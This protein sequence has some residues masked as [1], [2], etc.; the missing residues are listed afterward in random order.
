[1]LALLMPMPVSL[2]VLPTLRDMAPDPASH[3]GGIE[4]VNEPA[5]QPTAGNQ[6]NKNSS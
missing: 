5:L 3:A 2:A 4:G 1:V 6:A